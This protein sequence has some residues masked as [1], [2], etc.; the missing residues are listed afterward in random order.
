MIKFSFA[1]ETKSFENVNFIR[2]NKKFIVFTKLI[3]I[4]LDIF[5]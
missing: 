1:F 5:F 2:F 4:G 3:I